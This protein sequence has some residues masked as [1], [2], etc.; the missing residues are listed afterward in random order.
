MKRN[1]LVIV[2][3]LFCALLLSSILFP[4]FFGGVEFVLYSATHNPT[5]L[6]NKAVQKGDVRICS[7]IV[8]F[9]CD[10][11]GCE[12]SKCIMETVRKIGDKS[13]CK[14]EYFRNKNYETDLCYYTLAVSNKDESLCESVSLG[15][16][17]SSSFCYTKTAQAKD[18]PSICRKI[19]DMESD[20][21]RARCYGYFVEKNKDP[22]FCTELNTQKEREECYFFLLY[23]GDITTQ[24]CDTHFSNV[25]DSLYTKNQCFQRAALSMKDES[26]C[27]RIQRI[28]DENFEIQKSECFTDVAIEKKNPDLCDKIVDTDFRDRCFDHL[29]YDTQDFHV[30][31]RIKGEKRGECEHNLKPIS[32]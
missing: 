15:G 29:A 9:M 22:T 26:V 24:Y 13:A 14:G 25:I 20:D 4:D 18:D 10:G 17:P 12:Q 5:R 19:T 7:K 21:N 31:S 28:P 3:A 11:M 2:C 16:N 27:N 30:C 23:A 6:T 1:I 8:N 32:K